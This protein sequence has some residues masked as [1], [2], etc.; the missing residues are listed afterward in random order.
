[1]E[2]EMAASETS[3]SSDDRIITP[4][5]VR[6]ALGKFHPT[7][8]AIDLFAES[9]KLFLGEF[10]NITMIHTQHQ[11]RMTLRAQDVYYALHT[12]SRRYHSIISIERTIATIDSED[13]GE[14]YIED[15]EEEEEDE[16]EEEED[17]EEEEEEV[18]V[19]VDDEDEGE[20]EEVSDETNAPF[21]GSGIESFHEQTLNELNTIELFEDAADLEHPVDDFEHLFSRTEFSHLLQS[22]WNRSTPPEISRSAFEALYAIVEH[23]IL[24]N[25]EGSPR[26][27][28]MI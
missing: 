2:M 11:S 15:E 23:H 18:E 5:G 19:E 16:E 12:F 13:D 27:V 6:K 22:C 24:L 3:A 9:L 10:L 21:E 14:E 17:D 28:H 1:M 8:E 26:Y 7:D 25:L 4:A 20:E